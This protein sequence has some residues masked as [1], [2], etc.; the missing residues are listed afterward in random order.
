MLNMGALGDGSVGPLEHFAELGATSCQGATVRGLVI[1]GRPRTSA[2]RVD[3][4]RRQL[5]ETPIVDPLRARTTLPQLAAASAAVDLV[6]SNDTGP[7]HPRHG[8]RGSRG[9]DLYL[10]QALR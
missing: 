3:A 7:L 8:R 10:L 1:V 9:C 2:H 4:F 6:V 5:G